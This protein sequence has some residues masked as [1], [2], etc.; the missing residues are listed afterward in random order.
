MVGHRAVSYV[1][2]PPGSRQVHDAFLCVQQLRRSKRD[3]TQEAAARLA[4][5]VDLGRH[6]R[7]PDPQARPVRERAIPYGDTQYMYMHT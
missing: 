4:S 7:N 5:C 1:F 3:G 6:A 2:Y